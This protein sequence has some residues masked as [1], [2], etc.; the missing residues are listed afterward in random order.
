MFLQFM[1]VW[2]SYNFHKL[3]SIVICFIG[4][5][6]CHWQMKGTYLHMTSGYILCVIFL[7]KIYL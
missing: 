5:I 2:A 4:L 3:K 6:Y 1:K 7:S